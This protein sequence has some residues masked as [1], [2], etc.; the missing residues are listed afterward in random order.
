MQMKWQQKDVFV[1][2]DRFYTVSQKVST[3][4]LSLTLSNFNRFSNFCTAGKR[5]KFA[6][7]PIPQY[8]SLLWPALGMLL[9]YLGKL[10]IQFFCR[11]LAD[12]EENANKLHFKC[13]AFTS[14]TRVTV[15]VE[16]ICVNRIFETFKYTKA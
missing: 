6:T 14:Y 1:A 12:M 4:K 2:N 5:T 7:K 10:K 13:I 11:Y 9:H 15:Y 8:L 3:F 16:C